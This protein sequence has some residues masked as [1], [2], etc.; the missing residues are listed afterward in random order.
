MEERR[1]STCSPASV[2]YVS[3]LPN[4]GKSNCPIAPFFPARTVCLN[5]GMLMSKVKSPHRLVPRASCWWLVCQLRNTMD[6]DE[7]DAFMLRTR[8][9]ATLSP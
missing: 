8:I 1:L 3:S 4:E 5:T 9:V 6:G 7:T 2:V